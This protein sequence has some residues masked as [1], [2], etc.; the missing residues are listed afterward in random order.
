MCFVTQLQLS[1]VFQ[2]SAGCAASL[3]PH[4]GSHVHSSHNSCSSLWCVSESQSLLCVPVSVPF[5]CPGVCSMLC[6]HS[7]SCTDREPGAGQ[8]KKSLLHVRTPQCWLISALCLE[9][10]HPQVPSVIYTCP[11][12]ASCWRKSKPEES[13]FPTQAASEG[14]GIF[15]WPCFGA[16]CLR[17]IL[18]FGIVCTEGVVCLCK[19]GLL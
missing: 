11:S 3:E 10:A 1:V 16:Q 6:L 9:L 13:S 15:L 14:G 5:S 7:V 12:G 8:Y 2:L 19:R 4:F 18:L 17:I